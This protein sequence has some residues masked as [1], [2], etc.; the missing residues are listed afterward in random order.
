MVMEVFFRNSKYRLFMIANIVSALG[1]TLFGIVFVIY[2]RH[3]PNPTLAISLASVAGG[4]P[5]VLDVL[6]GYLADRA[7]N[8]FQQQLLNR[9]IQGGL[10][11]IMGGLLLKRAGWVTF[12]ALLIMNM[13][14]SLVGSYDLYGALAIIKDIVSAGDMA[15]A[16]GF[17]AGIN[18][19][20]SITGGLMGA[21]LLGL[22]RNNY[23]LFAWLNALSFFSAFIL[24]HRA[25]QDFSSISSSHVLIKNHSGKLAN[26][27][28]FFHQMAANITLLKTHTKITK[29]IGVFA[30]IN[31]FNAG[32]EV[33]LAL[34]LVQQ[35]QLIFLNYGYSV[36]LIGVVE[37]VGT[38]LGSLLPGRITKHFRITVEILFIYGVYGVVTLNSLFLK[39]RYVLLALIAT[40]GVLIGLLNPQVQSMMITTL[41]EETIGSIMSAFY[42]LVQ[43]T[44][45]VGSAV[46]A[47]IAN[48]QSLKIAWVALLGFDVVTLLMWLIQIAKSRKVGE[49]E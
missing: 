19:T 18:T 20:I 13:I 1:S 11:L 14:C 17:E 4:L 46:F 40:G 35:R 30:A 37:S 36:A 8:H 34:S 47:M 9:L 23:S 12:T 42:T 45:P 27:N 44:I 33:L 32:Q 10:F 38:I 26:V 2:A 49:D 21:A 7:S 16:E 41:P 24:L 25:R 48:G 28:Q 43:V 39:D 15:E 31:L 5:M 6:M 3:M 22:F 29:F